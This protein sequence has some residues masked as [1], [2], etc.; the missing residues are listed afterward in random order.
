MAVPQ[1]V[2]IQ[3][4]VYTLDSSTVPA[5]VGKDVNIVIG[6]MNT[7]LNRCRAKQRVRAGKL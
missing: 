3:E 4:L 2:T 5:A 1:A 6:G 7:G